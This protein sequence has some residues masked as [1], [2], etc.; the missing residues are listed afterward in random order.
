VEVVGILDRGGDQLSGIVCW[1]FGLRPQPGFTRIQQLFL[2]L[3]LDRLGTCVRRIVGTK[4]VLL[5]IG[6]DRQQRSC[7]RCRRGPAC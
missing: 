5:F 3:A 2:C 4:Q 6:C 7:N 1:R